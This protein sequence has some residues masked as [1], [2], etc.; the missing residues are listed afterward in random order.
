M[1]TTNQDALPM[2]NR[3]A[4]DFLLCNTMIDRSSINDDSTIRI[5][6]TSEH[7]ESWLGC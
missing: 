2:I 3:Y 4:A 6:D 1:K 5:A 7:A